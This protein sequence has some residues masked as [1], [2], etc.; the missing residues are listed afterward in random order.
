MGPTGSSTTAPYWWSRSRDAPDGSWFD[1]R[2]SFPHLYYLEP[3]QAP[4]KTACRA[5]IALLPLTTLGLA[6]HAGPLLIH[7]SWR[8]A[9]APT[10]VVYC[11]VLWLSSTHVFQQLSLTCT[12]DSLS[13]EAC[14]DAV[15]KIPVPSSTPIV[16]TAA[17][18]LA[19][20]G[21]ARPTQ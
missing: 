20:R 1:A 13:C 9:P 17:E 15:V 14:M 2:A 6:D 3:S 18:M 16:Q 11:R 7:T 21:I 10:S 5:N 19:P 12:V 8:V 4:Y